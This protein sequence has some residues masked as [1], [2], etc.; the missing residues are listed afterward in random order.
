VF[1]EGKRRCFAVVHTGLHEGRKN[2]SPELLV[3]LPPAKDDHA[4]AVD[5][6]V[7][8]SLIKH[9][10]LPAKDVRQPSK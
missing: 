10:M 5:P 6:P 3:E 7:I 8:P 1:K 2:V 4:M 9:G